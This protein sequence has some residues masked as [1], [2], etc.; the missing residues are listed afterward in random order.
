MVSVRSAYGKM[1]NSPA[2][3]ADMP[4][5]ACQ[6]FN[7]AVMLRSYTFM[8]PMMMNAMIIIMAMLITSSR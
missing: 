1:I 4:R 8:G 5:R 7:Y 3:N 2:F 6:V